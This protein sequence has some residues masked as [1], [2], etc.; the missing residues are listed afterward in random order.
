MKKIN[1]KVLCT[2]FAFLFL[3]VGTGVGIYLTNRPAVQNTAQSNA[4][5]DGAIFTPDDN[6]PLKL[7]T[8]EGRRFANGADVGMEYTITAVTEPTGHSVSWALSWKDTSGWASGKTLSNYVTLTSNG[9]T[10]TVKV[11]KA[12]GKQVILTCTAVDDPTVKATCTIDYAKRLLDVKATWTNGN[13]I[14]CTVQSGGT[15]NN[16]VFGSDLSWDEALSY[17]FIYSD[18]TIDVTYKFD[19]ISF[20]ESTALQ[21][22]LN[23]FDWQT[24]EDPPI[25]YGEYWDHLHDCEKHIGE[26][27]D[28]LETES[29]YVPSYN[30]I[31][32]FYNANKN[33]IFATATVSFT[34][35]IP[36]TSR[37]LNADFDFNLQFG[38]TSRSYMTESI[39]LSNTSVIA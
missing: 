9:S 31:L 3:L 27:Y 22:A 34:G 4:L 33:L 7:R 6:T 39:T 15:L 19:D 10:A 8:S 37:T 23:A 18:Y 32:D 26:I 5:P 13:D 24:V 11:N 29:G 14:D 36:G 35:T 28:S 16:L 2:A 1:L 12:F 25:V 38:S 30:E 17:E 20:C 21:T